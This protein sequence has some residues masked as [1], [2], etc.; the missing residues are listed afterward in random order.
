MKSPGRRTSL[1]LTLV[2][3]GMFGFGYALVPLYR[4]ICQITGFNG[5][6]SGLIAAQAVQE[7][8]DDSR[9]VSVQ[10]TTTVNGGRIWQFSADQSQIKVHPGKLYTVYFS[11]RNEQ[12]RHVVGQA[13]PSVVPW[14]AASYLHK[15]ECFC[16]A[17]QSF[18]PGEKKNMPVRF[19]IDPNL[20]K[21]VDMVTLSY[22]FFD[23]T[24]VADQAVTNKPS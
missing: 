9:L 10:F 8:E 3:A 4:T 13:V 22:T 20:P 19:M 17:R 12:D 23:V 11:A 1:V 2:V 5:K 16:F 24:Q 7:R 15:T 6:N 14:S 21:E 18:A